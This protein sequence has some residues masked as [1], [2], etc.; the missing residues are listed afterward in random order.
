MANSAR[1]RL[2][3]IDEGLRFSALAGSG[4][5][6]VV[7]SGPA[8]SA[9]SPIEMLLVSLA[10]CHAMDVISILRKMRQHV[11]AYE[12]DVSGERRTDH[13]KAFTRIEIVHH[14]TGHGLSAESVAHAIELSQTKYCSVT[15][16]LDPAISLSSRF[17]I[18]DA[19]GSTGTGERP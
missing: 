9:P 1:L 3:T 5:T 18:A 16:S 14:L 12:V 15:A 13:P 4:L 6:T 17:E 7:D 10:A 19:A 8:K 2:E 11:T